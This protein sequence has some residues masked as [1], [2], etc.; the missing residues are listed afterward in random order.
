MKK[1]RPEGCGSIRFSIKMFVSVV[2]LLVMAT[3]GA[4]AQSGQTVEATGK[5]LDG[6]GQPVIGA[7]VIVVGTYVGTTTDADG[8][9][10][11]KAQEGQELE[12]SFIGM[13][14]MLRRRRK[15]M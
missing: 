11:L 4:Y 5:V 3:A 6:S 14:R 9:F 13:S 12:I 8:N 1:N 7:S 10:M 2:L 15:R